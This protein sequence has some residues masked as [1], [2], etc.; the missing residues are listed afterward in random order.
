MDKLKKLILIIIFSIICIGINVF[1][2]NTFAT[3]CNGH[4][5]TIA[6]LQGDNGYSTGTL[7]QMQAAAAAADDIFFEFD[8]EK[9][10]RN[11]IG[12]TTSGNMG[13]SSY[14]QYNNKAVMCTTPESNHGTWA[15]QTG[16]IITMDGDG[17]VKISR[18]NSSRTGVETFTYNYSNPSERTFVKLAYEYAYYAMMSIKSNESAFKFAQTPYKDNLRFYSFMKDYATWYSHGMPSWVYGANGHATG[19]GY[20]RT[21]TKAAASAYIANAFAGKADLPMARFVWQRG[22]GYNDWGRKTIQ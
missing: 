20:K 5:V 8:D 18:L 15:Q 14:Y 2:N 7:D 6:D 16:L 17:G 11:A 22:W 3:T 13:S 21:Q 1:C 10:L 12:K 4:T 19:S 9:L